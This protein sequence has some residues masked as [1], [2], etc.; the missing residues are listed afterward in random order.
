MLR[1]ALMGLM[2]PRSFFNRTHGLRIG[3]ALLGLALALAASAA[4]EQGAR[5]S[6]HRVDTAAP[7]QQKVNV[8]MTI[9]TALC[10]DTGRQPYRGRIR[11]T[12]ARDVRYD[13]VERH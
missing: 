4:D 2:R 5:V 10:R 8:W 13:R 9:G 11:A 7:S 6:A 1:T 12:A 3:A